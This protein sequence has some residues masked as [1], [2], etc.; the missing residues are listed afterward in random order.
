[1]CNPN[2][3]DAAIRRHNSNHPCSGYNDFFTIHCYCLLPPKIDTQIL[4]KSEEVIVNK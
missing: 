4:V 2:T 3:I 1:M